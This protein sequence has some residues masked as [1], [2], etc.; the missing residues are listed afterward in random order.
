M[1]NPGKDHYHYKLLA[2]NQSR[3]FAWPSS[4]STWK[5]YRDS[6]ASFGDSIYC[7][8]PWP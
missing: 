1:Q 8:I 6:V 3:S 7:S 4:I 2:V 5:V